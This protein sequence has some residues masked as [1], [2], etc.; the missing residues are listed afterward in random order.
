MDSW[1]LGGHKS[2]DVDHERFERRHGALS[3]FYRH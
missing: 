2:R 3:C 1:A